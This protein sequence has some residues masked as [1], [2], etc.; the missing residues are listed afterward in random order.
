MAKKEELTIP[1]QADELTASWFTD[2]LDYDD[3]V[4][5]VERS[6]V[7]TDIGFMGE[8]Y[9]CT[10]NWE[11]NTDPELPKSVIV[12]IP[13]NKPEN[14]ALGEGIRAYEREIVIYGEFQ[15]D[16]GIPMPKAHYSIMDPDPA[17]WAERPIM[18]LFEKLPIGGVGWLV[19]KF[20]DLS[21]KMPPRRYLLMIEDI[22][23]ARP[24]TQAEGGSLEDSEVALKILAKFHAKNWMRQKA[25]DTSQRIMPVDATPK[26]FQ[27]AYRRNREIFV[28][29]WG[30]TVGPEVME[31]L[32]RFDENLPKLASELVAEPWTV[33]HGDYRLDNVLFRSDDEVVV[34]DYQL[35][36]WGRAGYDVAYFIT[37]ALLPE[38]KSEEEALLRVY[39]D[40]LTEAGVTDYS[41]EALV[42]DC[43]TTKELLAHRFVGGRDFVD[44]EVEASDDTFLDTLAVRV[45]GWLN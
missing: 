35:V 34:I 31:R 24:P 15:D 42:K 2:V 33:V 8:L 38:H 26:I 22:D 20:M 28:E 16:L 43:Q 32:D 1:Q 12:K 39:H 18:F 14:R 10:L 25:L 13:S 11:H 45:L 37:T 44:T 4:T 36:G 41:Y 7:G 3:T 6:V 40:A 21:T 17:P 23:D 9:R 29:Q 27:S 30:D 19:Q 5:S